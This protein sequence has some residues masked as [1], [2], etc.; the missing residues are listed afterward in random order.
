MTETAQSLQKWGY[1]YQNLGIM[2]KMI[3]GLHLVAC[4]QAYT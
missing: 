1:T 4:I 3:D 2:P